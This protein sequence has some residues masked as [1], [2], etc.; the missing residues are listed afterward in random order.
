MTFFVCHASVVFSSFFK[1]FLSGVQSA[2][3]PFS[4]KVEGT[5]K[6]DIFVSLTR[7]GTSDLVI[8]AK[9]SVSEHFS[10]FEFVFFLETTII[11]Q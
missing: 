3:A 2:L 9:Q 5:E 1:V 7:S 8:Y 11:F 6:I 10:S 4:S